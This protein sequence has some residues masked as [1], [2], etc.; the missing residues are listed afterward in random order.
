[1]ALRLCVWGMLG[2][3]KE[4]TA[5]VCDDSVPPGGGPQ[6]VAGRRYTRPRS[7]P[8]ARRKKAWRDRHVL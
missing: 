8:D 5:P 2:Q 1:M 3:S 4:G 7:E 6:E